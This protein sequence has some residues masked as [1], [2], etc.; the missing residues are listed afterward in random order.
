MKMLNEVCQAVQSRGFHNRRGIQERPLRYAPSN[1]R[2]SALKKLAIQCG[3]SKEDLISLRRI[4][5]SIGS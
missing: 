4:P 5:S 1:N 3:K 2:R